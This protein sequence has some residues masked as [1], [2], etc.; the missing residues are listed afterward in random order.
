LFSCRWK[1][2]FKDVLN[3]WTE[4]GAACS[5]LPS[6][7]IFNTKSDVDS[8]KLEAHLSNPANHVR[9]PGDA[10]SSNV[11]SFNVRPLKFST[12]QHNYEID[13]K[14]MVQVNLNPKVG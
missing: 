12:S 1:W 2:Y 13:F 5:Y 3:K 7:P 11:S 4:Y 14:D 6:I 9:D 10:W 8:G